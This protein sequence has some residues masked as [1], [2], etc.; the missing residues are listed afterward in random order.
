MMLQIK[1]SHLIRSIVVPFIDQ[2][3]FTLQ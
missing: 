1:K 3:N 2:N